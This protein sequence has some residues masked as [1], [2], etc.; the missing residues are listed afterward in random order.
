MF[1][2]RHGQCQFASLVDT[3]RGNQARMVHSR[4]T[5]TRARETGRH[6]ASLPGVEVVRSRHTPTLI[7][8][9]AL[10]TL[11]GAGSVLQLTATESD[12][13]AYVM[14]QKGRT[15]SRGDLAAYMLGCYINPFTDLMEGL[16]TR[17]QSR[18]AATWP[19]CIDMIARSR[20]GQFYRA[21]TAITMLNPFE[22]Q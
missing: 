22:R 4:R 18:I 9:P 17:I 14:R 11:S 16:V 21:S 5:T 15:A 2:S 19:E 1:R 6:Q 8:D 3:N 12:L 20:N 10:R 13:I 7:F